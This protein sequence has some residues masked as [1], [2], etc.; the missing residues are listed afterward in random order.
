MKLGGGV[1]GR[2]ELEGEWCVIGVKCSVYIHV[3]NCQ[4]IVFFK[5]ELAF[6]RAEIILIVV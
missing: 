6:E 5:K 3:W 2:K 1:G 4:K